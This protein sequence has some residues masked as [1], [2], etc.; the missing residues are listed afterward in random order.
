MVEK[1]G[2]GNIDMSVTIGPPI[3][4][5]APSPSARTRFEFKKNND[6]TPS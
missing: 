6:P 1:Y 2:L 5:R 3:G 4:L